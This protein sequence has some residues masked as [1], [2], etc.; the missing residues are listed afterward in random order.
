MSKTVQPQ[1]RVLA[2]LMTDLCDERAIR[3]ATQRPDVDADIEV[4]LAVPPMPRRLNHQLTTDDRHEL[5]IANERLEN[6][7]RQLTERGISAS[8]RVGDLSA[9]P[10]QMID[11]AIAY[12]H[13]DEIVLVVRPDDEQEWSEDGA[14]TKTMTTYA[15]PIT[16]VECSAELDRDAELGDS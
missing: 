8:G 15:L 6:S 3:K 1:Y 14:I 9:G 4:Y 16:I 11:D 10:E 7:L 2:L 12:F 13:P 5:P